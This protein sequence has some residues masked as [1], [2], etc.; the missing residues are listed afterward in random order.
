MPRLSSSSLDFAPRIERVGWPGGK[1]L[2][3]LVH[4]H[5]PLRLSSAFR[6]GY[7]SDIGCLDALILA[8]ALKSIALE[9]FRQLL[10][11][12]M[13]MTSGDGFEQA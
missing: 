9:M 10:E 12:D 3:G 1:Q 13:L 7:E 11:A 5:P 2:H 6:I 8:S 4:C